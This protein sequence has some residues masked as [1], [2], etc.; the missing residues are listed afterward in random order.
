MSVTRGAAGA[1]HRERFVTRRVE[2]HDAAAADVDRIRADVLRDAAGFALG[3]LRL[4]DRV[5]QRRLAVV[6]VAHDGDD[7]RAR[8]RDP[9][10][11]DASVSTS[12]SSSSK[13]RI[14]TSAPKSRAIICRRVRVERRV[15][16]HHHAAVHELLQ[17]VLDLDLEL[18]GEVL[19]RHAFGQRDELGDRAAAPP[20]TSAST[21]DR[22]GA[23][24]AAGADRPGGTA[25][26]P[27]GRHAGRTARR[28]GRRRPDRLRRQ[29][30]RAAE[31]RPRRRAIA[32]RMRGRARGRRAAARP[33][34]VGAGGA[35]CG[36][37]DGP[38]R[39]RP[40]GRRFAGQRI[41]DAQPARRRH[42]P[43][44]RPRRRAAAAAAPA[45][46]R[47]RPPASTR[48]RLP[49]AARRL[50]GRLDDRGR[51]VDSQLRLGLATGRLGSTAPA[52][53]RRPRRRPARRPARRDRCVGVDATALG[54][55]SRRA[56]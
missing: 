6:D 26:R 8:R 45:A 49:V 34:R 25:R 14:S 31:R 20:A 32:G 23:S 15:D 18:V 56:A 22:R 48:P 53:R 21:A 51:F 16:G 29:R 3:D 33:G 35:C 30:T 28:A 41:L 36:R 44:G 46:P 40:R 38:L 43:A 5:E 19:D 11:L 9:P 12:V 24:S 2:E 55:A 39:H 27:G 52:R 47:R 13:L 10:G 54:I 50:D 1:H 37:I 42:Q 7:R 4:A 17:D